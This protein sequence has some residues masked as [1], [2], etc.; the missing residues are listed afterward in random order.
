MLELQSKR[1][2]VV[3]IEINIDDY[4]TENITERRC[5]GRTPAATDNKFLMPFQA[6]LKILL[7]PTN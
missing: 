4:K 5:S 2:G 3:V 1:Q 7:S 6:S